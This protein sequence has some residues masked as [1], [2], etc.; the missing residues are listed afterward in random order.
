MF[1]DTTGQ[2]ANADGSGQFVLRSK[3]P[4]F[5]GGGVQALGASG[6]VPVNSSTTARTR[7]I[8]DATTS[9]W[10]WVDALNAFAVASDIG[11]GTTISFWDADFTYHPYA[12]VTIPGAQREGPGLVRRPDG[13]APVSTID[14]CGRV[15]LDVMRATVEGAG[16]NGISHFGLDVHGLHACR[17]RATTLA[18]MT[19]FVVPSPDR[20]VDI[21]LGDKLL[22]VE[23]R[24]VAL[25]LGVGS[26]DQPPAVIATLPVVASL[27]AGAQAVSSPGHPLGMLLDGGR[28]WLVGDP[29][30]A[31]LNSS[32]VATVSA[33]QWAAYPL[34]S[35]LTG[36]RP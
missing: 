8:A 18:L 28:L 24:S 31:A 27:K 20:T 34:G 19:G 9:D 33:T 21:V 23:R 32:P 10:M 35:D 22:E 29:S 4:T 13:H 14:P 30:V 7:S 25:A 2:A 11:D 1:T 15:P 16:P 17:E 12:S 3:D 26:V 6:F 5:Q 36:L